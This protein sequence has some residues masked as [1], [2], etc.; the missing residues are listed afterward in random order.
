[1]RVANTG[2]DSRLVKI[3]SG[4]IACIGGIAKTQINAVSP[5]VNGSFQSGQATS[6]ADQLE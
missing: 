1:M 2:V 6:R 4:K 5:V 3:E